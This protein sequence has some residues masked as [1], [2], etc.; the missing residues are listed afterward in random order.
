M[1][2]KSL[3]R[4]AKIKRDEEIRHRINAGRVAIKDQIKFFRRHFGQVSSDWKADASRVTFADIAISENLFASLNRDFPDDDYCSEEMS[5]KDASIQL[6]SNF[7]WVLDPV[8]GT[9]NFALGFPLCAISLA[10]LYDGF[11]V[12]GFVYDFSTNCLLEGGPSYG[13][14]KDQKI[15][16]IQ[17]KDRKTQGIVGVQFPIEPRLLQKLSP[18]LSEM[19][20]RSLGSS[21][22]L[23]S[24][25]SQAYLEGVIDVR[26]KVW[27]ISATYALAEAVG[28]AF[29][30]LG[31]SAFPLK[32]FHPSLPTCPYYSGTKAFCRKMKLL[33]T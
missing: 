26:A 7:A 9:N 5:S 19:K 29:Y 6:K 27:D 14:M 1:K 33:V 12:Y 16:S 25:C 17:K 4:Q 3:S 31:K 8:D 28:N 18:I 20:I 13:L 21:T 11:P 2:K 32:E 15:Y 23:G 24:L 10:L 22:L 30:F